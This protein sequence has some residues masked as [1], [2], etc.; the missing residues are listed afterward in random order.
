[1]KIPGGY[2]NPDHRNIGRG[3]RAEHLRGCA[4]AVVEVHR[5]GIGVGHDVLI[6]DDVALLVVDALAPSPSVSWL[7][8]PNR[9]EDC[10][11]VTVMSTTPGLSVR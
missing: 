1:M 2:V 6:G 11:E 5:D 10:C 8:P 4:D 3:I 9:V 7:L